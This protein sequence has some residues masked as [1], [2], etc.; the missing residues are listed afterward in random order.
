MIVYHNRVFWHSDHFSS[1]GLYWDWRTLRFQFEC[2][3]GNWRE[4]STNFCYTAT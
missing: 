3:L 2:L 4:G 1:T